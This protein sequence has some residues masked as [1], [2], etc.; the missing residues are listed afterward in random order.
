MLD[1]SDTVIYGKIGEN[2]HIAITVR[3]NYVMFPGIDFELEIKIRHASTLSCY[4]TDEYKG[5]EKEFF[6][7][8]ELML[9]AISEI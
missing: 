5:T 4:M 3:K 1:E 2:K 6:N 8:K 7:A 9:K